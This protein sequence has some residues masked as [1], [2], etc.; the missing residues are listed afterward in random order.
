MTVPPAS[1][2]VTGTAFRPP[3]IP[4]KY[5]VIPIHSSDRANFKRCRRYWD[6]SS[7]ARHNLTVRADIHGVNKP[8]W[9]GT[10]IHWALEQY[11]NPGLSHDPVESWKTWF[12][13]QWR[14]GTVTK[15]W[16]DKVYDL[17]PKPKPGDVSLWVV[18][19]LEDILPD[20]DHYEFDEL[21][22]LG[23]QMMKFYK[24]YAI[25]ND[26]FIVYMTEHD[27][28]V[29]IW[30]Y[31]NNCILK[32]TD[33]REES[34]NYG[35]VL[36]VHARGRQ[37]GLT[38]RPSGKMGIIDH[39]TAAKIE[40]DYF[41]KLETDEQCTT[42]LWAAEVEA[43]YYD[44]PHKGEPLEE[45]IYNTLRKAYPSPPTELKNG[46]FSVDRTNESTTYE[47][48]TEWISKN[49]PGV[50]LSEK[51]QEYVDYLRKTGDEQFIIRKPV[52]RNR[53]QL[54]N[55]GYR[56]YLEALDMLDS[57]VRIYPNISNT[58]Q[59]IN[60]AFRIPCIAKEDGGDWQALIEDNYVVAKD[61]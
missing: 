16:L 32:R 4:N 1:A 47:M 60:C 45:I 39:K 3:E 15:E 6:W 35:K 9:F 53:H 5:D 61:R 19:G 38:V 8:M 27:F 20:P 22:E 48:L 31:E 50:Q 58:F 21:K 29:P 18:R 57:A 34:P 49:I 17:K 14:G 43:Q 46:M 10:G 40:E 56:I 33:I 59:C 7:P 12:D 23:I 54:N 44:L 11:Y 36:E 26:D 24:E 37:D 13:I 30:D 25:K 41:I 51:Q 55:A 2:G 52:R 42:Y 28:S